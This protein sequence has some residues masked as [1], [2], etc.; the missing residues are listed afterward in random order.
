VQNNYRFLYV[1]GLLLFIAVSATPSEAQIHYPIR[2]VTGTIGA[3]V[4]KTLL[5][6][7]KHR[8]FRCPEDQKPCKNLTPLF[9]GMGEGAGTTLGAQYGKPLFGTV[10]ASVGARFSTRRYRRYAAGLVA[11]AGRVQTGPEVGYD[12]LAEQD[13]FGEGSD[14]N[15]ADRTTYA[16]TNKI[17]RWNTTVKLSNVHLR[18]SLS[19]NQYKV[20]E[21]RDP[22]FAT[23]Q[24]VFEPSE[25]SGAYEGT[26]YITNQ[27]GA[28]LDLRDNTN[29]PRSG[30]AFDASASRQ[31]G[32]GRTD[33]DFT[34]LRLVNY[35][36][37]P[38]TS[39]RR[40]L[41]AF[42]TEVVRNLSD[43]PIPFYLQPTLGGSGTLRGFREYRFHDRDA[44]AFTAEYRYRVWRYLDT[45]L[46][47]DFGQVYTNVFQQMGERGL[48][49]AAG[50]GLRLTTPVVLLRL[51]VGHSH[52]GNRL[53]LS[54]GQSW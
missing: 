47:G 50:V 52:E 1:M 53:F 26:R 38:F 12:Y 2:W 43:D 48:E 34:T 19:W 42:R 15:N 36:Y 16:L 21:G 31:N 4:N 17:A 5:F 29:D 35:S 49:S 11:T 13:F 14:S 9:G 40:Q 33:S 32:I 37:V 41:M 20:A 3:G 24:E 8:Y 6:F 27:V 51:S 45:V 46:F 28:F 18:H 7:E 22:R 23:T 10:R 44:F 25:V 54:F 39:E 30:T